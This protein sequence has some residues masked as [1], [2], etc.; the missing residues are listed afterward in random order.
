V[1]LCGVIPAHLEAIAN[2]FTRS[3]TQINYAND[4]LRVIGTKN[5][6][7][8]DKIT[9]SPHP[10]FPTD[11]QPQLMAYLSLA[12]GTSIISETVYDGRFRHVDELQRMG[13]QIY[14]DYHTAIIRGVP[15][16]TSARVEAT[17][18][19]A[20]AALILAGI[21]AEGRTIIEKVSHIDRGYEY[22]EQMFTKIGANIRRNQIA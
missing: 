7:A 15:K 6:K 14:V 16:L 2:V 11:M 21:A 3:G 18:L 20:G 8:I 5:P 9:T 10:G 19:R 17:D 22:V 13:A 12:N 4:M 1:A